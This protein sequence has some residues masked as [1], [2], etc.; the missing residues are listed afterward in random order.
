MQLVQALEIGDLVDVAGAVTIEA[1]ASLALDDPGIIEDKTDT[2]IGQKT[3]I[4]LQGASV[5]GAGF[6][7]KYLFDEV[8]AG[9]DALGPDNKLI[10]APGTLS[11]T[12]LVNTSRLISLFL[13][14]LR[15]TSVPVTLG[16]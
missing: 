3:Q 5:G 15:T 10:F 1:G 14:T 13:Q 12:V 8:P 4:V 6:G 7:I 9:A 2:R 16:V 11:G